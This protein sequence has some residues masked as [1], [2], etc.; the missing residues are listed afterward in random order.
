MTG[1]LQLSSVLCSPRTS[2]RLGSNPSVHLACR[3]LCSTLACC[4]F[5]SSFCLLLVVLF[6]V[7]FILSPLLDDERC[8]AS[9]SSFST[10]LSPTLRVQLFD[11]FLAVLVPLH[12]SFHH[13][14]R[15]R[16]SSSDS[17]TTGCGSVSDPLQRHFVVVYSSLDAS[18]APPTPLLSIASLRE[19]WLA[20][21][22][23]APWSL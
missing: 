4:W 22:V 14:L 8:S 13:L 19:R 9:A 23:R 15:G 3:W 12:S 17:L 21:R 6:S 16:G 5:T 7:L 18:P 1:W 10:S 2:P 20:I 11:V